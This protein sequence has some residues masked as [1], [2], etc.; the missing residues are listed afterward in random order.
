M[1]DLQK[2]KFEL[3]SLISEKTQ[4]ENQIWH[5]EARKNQFALNEK[6]NEDNYERNKIID[7]EIE[8]KKGKL[9]YVEREINRYEKLIK[10]AELKE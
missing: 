8:L 5:E 9:S 3:S 6:S 1:N 2:L 10:K 7:R 4:I